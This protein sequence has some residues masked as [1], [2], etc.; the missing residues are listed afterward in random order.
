MIISSW[1]RITSR[2]PKWMLLTGLHKALTWIPLIQV[3]ILSLKA[4]LTS[5][6]KPLNFSLEI[7]N[8]EKGPLYFTLLCDSALFKTEWVTKLQ[9]VFDLACSIILL[10]LWCLQCFVLCYSLL[11]WQCKTQ[12][13]KM[14]GQ[15]GEKSWLWGWNQVGLNGGCVREM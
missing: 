9:W 1:W 6:I 11:G 4:K 12:G 10:R 8:A 2:W 15:T 14:S 7:E 13:C 3:I 5:F